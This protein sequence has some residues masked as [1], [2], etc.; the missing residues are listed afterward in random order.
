MSN[1]SHPNG[2]VTVA[3]R[4]AVV[5]VYLIQ[6]LLFLG[7]ASYFVF[8]E[9]LGARRLW[10]VPVLAIVTLSFLGLRRIWRQASSWG[11]DSLRLMAS[12]PLG[13]F[14]FWGPVSYLVVDVLR[15][16]SLPGARARLL[17][18]VGNFVVEVF[19]A[20]GFSSLS[21]LFFLSNENRD[22]IRNAHP[23]AF[24]FLALVLIGV[25]IAVVT[26]YLGV[27]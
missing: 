20:I 2:C 18:G 8:A 19:L 15:M 14:L 22:T 9:G 21:A 16:H 17:K 10:L 25:L 24:Y 7:I 3:A 13:W 27:E 6:S 23:R 4:T 1:D 5:L 11:L 12:A 26:P